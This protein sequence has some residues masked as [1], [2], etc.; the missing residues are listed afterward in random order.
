M[1]ILKRKLMLAVLRKKPALPRLE[2]CDRMRP[3]LRQY[4]LTLSQTEILFPEERPYIQNLIRIAKSFG[5]YEKSIPYHA[6]VYIRETSEGLDMML[7]TGHV[8]RFSP[9]SPVW[10]IDNLYNY[11]EPSPVTVWWWG[12]SGNMT[13]LWW[14]IKRLFITPE[15]EHPKE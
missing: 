5:I 2:V 3:Y 11:G 8:F 1:N 4:G 7:R 12:F 10:L 9:E 14:K 6:V 13:M 15:A